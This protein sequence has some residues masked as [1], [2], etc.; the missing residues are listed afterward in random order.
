MLETPLFKKIIQ[1]Y[2]ME[3][4]TLQRR[5]L[6]SLL[7]KRLQKKLDITLRTLLLMTSFLTSGLELEVEQSQST[8]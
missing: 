2:K 7:Q 6:L 1:I 3:L 8:V 5:R 4:S